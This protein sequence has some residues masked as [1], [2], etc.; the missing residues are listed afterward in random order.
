MCSYDNV[1][2]STEI[3]ADLTL[4]SPT[5]HEEGDTRVV[6][7]S[8]DMISKGYRRIVIRTVDTDVLV[9]MVSFFHELHVPDLHL[10]VDF[11]VGKNRELFSIN[12]ISD[13]LGP[14][15][16]LA[17]R[18]FYG[19]TGVDQNS[20]FS[21]VT[22]HNAW[23]L[24]LVFPDITEAFA[25]LSSQPT[26][27]EVRDIFPTVERFVVLLYS[28]SSNALTC[29]D[30]RREL[31]CEGRSID[32]IPPT[33]AALFQHVLRAVFVTGYYWAQATVSMQELP[34]PEDWGWK[35]VDDVYVPHWTE[36]PEASVALRD[37]VKCGCKNNTCRGN[38]KCIKSGDL[39]CTELC[40]CKGQ[41]ER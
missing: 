15:K 9:L 37:L 31:F 20:F 13:A 3:F 4:L 14:E 12:D 33:S 5:N 29:N 8:K 21:H 28:R 18:F 39:P 30:A 23:K 11:G 10:W 27:E 41:C 1:A 26:L 6:L 40:K 32:A 17:T 7:H 22:K 25:K 2:Q 38:C 19:L 24:W 36:L 34:S 35:L 16:S